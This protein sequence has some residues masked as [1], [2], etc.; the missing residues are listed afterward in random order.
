MCLESLLLLPA[1]E[2]FQLTTPGLQSLQCPNSEA[3]SPP[4]RELSALIPFP[5]QASAELSRSLPA[6]P[7]PGVKGVKGDLKNWQETRTYVCMHAC[8]SSA[9]IVPHVWLCA[10]PDNSRLFQRDTVPCEKSGAPVKPCSSGLRL[11]T[12]PVMVS[13]VPILGNRACSA[14]GV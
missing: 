13:G 12:V 10:T 7:C 5:G 4:S 1:H 14:S 9:G 3:G 11:P 6:L 8:C 2:D